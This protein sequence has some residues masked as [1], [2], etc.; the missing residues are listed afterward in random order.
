MDDKDASKFINLLNDDYV[1]SP[2]T[3]MRYE[4]VNKKALKVIEPEN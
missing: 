4:I 3:G 1:E 2:M